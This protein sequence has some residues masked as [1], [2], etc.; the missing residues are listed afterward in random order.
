MSAEFGLDQKLY[1]AVLRTVIDGIVSIDERG[2]ILSFNPAAEKIF[3]YA[4]GE[5]IG[6]NVTMLM[7]EPYRGAHDGYIASYLETGVGSIIGIGREAKG[8]RKDGSVFPL[9]LGV[10]EVRVD[11]TPYFTGILRDLSRERELEEQMRQQ[12]KLAAVGQLAAGI[13]HE[14]GNPLAAISGAIQVMTA[15]TEHA[16]IREIAPQLNEQIERIGAIVRKL[17]DFARPPHD[18]WVPC[19]LNDVVEQT[20]EILRYDKRSLGVAIETSFDESLPLTVARPGQ[21]SQ[22]FVN[23]LLNALDA[24]REAA[25]AEPSVRIATSTRDAGQSIAVVIEDNGPGIPDAVSQRV[26][27]PFF[28]TKEVG[29]GTGL[30]L[31]VSYGI[32][33]EHG[34]EIEIDGRPGEGAQFT[35]K[36]PVRERAPDG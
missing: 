28:T 12:E 16:T 26:F 10:S 34:G 15:E 25:V 9:H 20:I 24:L 6:E 22:V 36:L 18:E 32:V 19:L 3:G 29:K 33:S 23:L 8:Q 27:D 35:V 5:V 1:E 30:G 21:L 4:A 7:P 31:S 13:A 2:R 17:L 14:I 11:G